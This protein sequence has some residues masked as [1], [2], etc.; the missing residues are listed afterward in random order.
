MSENQDSKFYAYEELT[1]KEKTALVDK[2]LSWLALRPKFIDNIND[3]KELFEKV[4]EFSKKLYEYYPKERI[5]S[6]VT[7]GEM[8]GL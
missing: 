7:F 1:S 4:V 5:K 3:E 2:S 6:T 8:K